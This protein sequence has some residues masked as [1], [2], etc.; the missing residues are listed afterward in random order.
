MQVV[1]RAAAPLP[2][3]MR[4]VELD[5]ASASVRKPQA[6]R[7]LQGTTRAPLHPAQA[8]LTDMAARTSCRVAKM[9]GHEVLAVHAGRALPVL[10]I[11]GG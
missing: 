8:V 10:Y 6:R 7:A 1:Q 2:T 3:P 11:N 4:S 9:L 5:V